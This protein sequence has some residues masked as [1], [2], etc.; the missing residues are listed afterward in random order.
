MA[1]KLWTQEEINYL[2]FNYED[3]Y[4]VSDLNLD[5]SE[6]SIYLKAMQLCLKKKFNLGNQNLL[7]FGKAHRF[8][9]GNIPH[10]KGTIGL[11]KPNKTSFKKGDIPVNIKYNGDPYFYKRK[12]K[13]EK[14][15]LIQP[16]GTN[17][18]QSYSKY[19]WELHN[20]VIQK[21]CII[22]N[23]NFSDTIPPVIEDLRMISRGENMDANSIHRYPPELKKTF[24]LI[25]KL[26][27]L[28][29]TNKK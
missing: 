22:K 10:N 15:W 3:C 28:T 17:K 24:K 1:G 14:T 21:N 4:K 27:N 29:N 16:L 6:K 13:N 5:R 25:K 8:P 26:N 19:L 12:S 9:K 7:E 18:R 20:G 11:M 23:I 2:K